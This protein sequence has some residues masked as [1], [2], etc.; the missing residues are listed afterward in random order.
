MKALK[1]S[2]ELTQT[3]MNFSNLVRHLVVISKNCIVLIVS[4]ET[5]YLFD[6]TCDHSW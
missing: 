4:I 5:F 1:L 3:A 2:A 6:F